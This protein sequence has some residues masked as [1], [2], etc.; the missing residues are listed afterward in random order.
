MPGDRALP[1]LGARGWGSLLSW[2]RADIHCPLM[3]PQGTS[4][5]GVSPR[6]PGEPLS[7]RASSGEL[8]PLGVFKGPQSPEVLSP[9][10]AVPAAAR[11]DRTSTHLQQ[12]GEA[13]RGK[14][15]GL[16]S[17]SSRRAPSACLTARPLL[18]LPLPS[19]GLC[20]LTSKRERARVAA[21][22]WP[23]LCQASGS[24]PSTQGEGGRLLL[25]SSRLGPIRRP[26]TGRW[27]CRAGPWGFP[28]RPSLPAGPPPGLA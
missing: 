20:I 3:L 9:C 27:P 13:Q 21:G 5:H 18:P 28:E 25:L 22:R 17:H 8:E 26:G 24:L 7:L 19:F 2:A 12:Q 10:Q 16:Q 14:V 6:G 4:E 1:V 15:T 11:S 23:R